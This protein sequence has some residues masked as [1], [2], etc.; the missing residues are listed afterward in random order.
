MKLEELKTSGLDALQTVPGPLVVDGTLNPVE[1]WASPGRTLFSGKYQH[2]GFNHQVSCTLNGKLLAITDPGPGTSHNVYAFRSHQLERFLD[3]STLADKGHIGLGPL[4]PIKRKAGVRIRVAV[5][6]NNRQFNRL[7]SVFEWLI[8]QV[9][10][11]RVLHSV[12][13]RPWVLICGCFSYC[14]C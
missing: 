13:R 11:W 10:T 14:R 8:A 3:E 12:Y 6:E 1:N 5:K 2:T 4:T 7:R 9:K